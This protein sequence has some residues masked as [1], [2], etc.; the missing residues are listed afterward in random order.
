MKPSPAWMADGF[1]YCDVG[2]PVPIDRLFTYE[3]PLPL[4][5]AVHA[6]CRVLVNFGARKLTGVVA[7]V[8]EQRPEQDAREILKLID[9]E[10][11]LDS[12]LLV[13][14]H[15]ISEYYCAPIGEVL[16]SMLPLSGE[17][18]RLTQYALTDAGRDVARQLIVTP[19]SDAASRILAALAE[20]ALAGNSLTRKIRNARPALQ[21]LVKRG[22]IRKEHYEQERDPFS[23]CYLHAGADNR[24]GL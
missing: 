24:R 19:E 10:P 1:R 8:H 6:G 14:A 15:W 18:R 16:K 12:E 11:V 23:G 13:L 17:S 4:R 2:L 20:R 3:V 7:D 22:W 9:Q 21:A 5:A